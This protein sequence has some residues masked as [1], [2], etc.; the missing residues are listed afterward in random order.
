MS[1][2]WGLTGSMDPRLVSDG[3][4]LDVV[5]ICILLYYIKTHACIFV[6]VYKPINI[7]PPTRLGWRELDVV[8]PFLYMLAYSYLYIHMRGTLAPP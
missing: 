6:H 7:N 2:M 4:A 1:V 5:C 8:R 3:R